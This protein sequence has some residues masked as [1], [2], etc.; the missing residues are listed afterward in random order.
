MEAEV[1]AI[2]AAACMTEADV[3]KAVDALQDLVD[4]LYG[5]HK[6]SHVVDDFIAERRRESARE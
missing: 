3:N 6:P 1:R 4:Q 5:D 2:L